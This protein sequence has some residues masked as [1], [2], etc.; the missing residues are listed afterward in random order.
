[1]TFGIAPVLD[2][3]SVRARQFLPRR[4]KVRD[5]PATPPCA[6]LEPPGSRMRA[7]LHRPGL[8]SDGDESAAAR[9]PAQRH[10]RPDRKQRAHQRDRARPV[11]IE[12]SRDLEVDECGQHIELAAQERWHTEVADGSHKD[13]DRTGTWLS[14][15]DAVTMACIN[16]ARLLGIEPG[17][18]V[19]GG[20][21]DVVVLRHARG[22][23][24][25]EVLGTVAA[26]ERVWEAG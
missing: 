15:A 13:D 16:P 17:L 12:A 23:E 26:G 11:Q 20:R 9:D 22:S 5:R 1:V 4:L 6:E 18:L 14:L 19:Q 21:G 10:Q 8:R 25:V 2:E 7:L 3:N 24:R